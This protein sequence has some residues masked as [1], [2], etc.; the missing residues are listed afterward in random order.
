MVKSL[1]KGVK[2]LKRRIQFKGLL[3]GKRIRVEGIGI[4]LARMVKKTKMLNSENS[5]KVKKKHKRY[6]SIWCSTRCQMCRK[7]KMT[8]TIS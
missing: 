3:G 7:E 4:E 1:K 8:T 6:D 5:N 2:Q